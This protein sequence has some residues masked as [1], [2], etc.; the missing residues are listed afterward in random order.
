[1]IIILV[2]AIAAILGTQNK[3]NQAITMTTMVSEQTLESKYIDIIPTIISHQRKKEWIL[4]E[5]H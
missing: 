4:I 3:N 2:V 1:M 5:V